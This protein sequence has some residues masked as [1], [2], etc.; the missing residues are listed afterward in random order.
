MVRFSSALIST[1]SAWTP[2][3]F[4]VVA[5]LLLILFTATP[6]PTAP[7]PPLAA[8]LV[9][10]SSISLLALTWALPFFAVITELS[11]EVATLLFILLTVTA[12]PTPAPIPIAKFAFTAKLLIL[13]TLLAATCTSLAAEEIWAFFRAAWVVLLSLITDTPAEALTA[14]VPPETA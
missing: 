2:L 13:L 1:A 3:L 8:A 4:R 11:T 5:V 12:V 7:T 10:W 14:A 6:T 9:L